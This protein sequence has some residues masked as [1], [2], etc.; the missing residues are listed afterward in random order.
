MCMVLQAEAARIS[1]SQAHALAVV[2]DALQHHMAGHL[3]VFERKLVRDWER[4]TFV[5]REYRRHRAASHG[6][7]RLKIPVEGKIL[8]ERLRSLVWLV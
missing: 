7:E 2:R 3:P 4:K 5:M 1:R 6:G 8:P